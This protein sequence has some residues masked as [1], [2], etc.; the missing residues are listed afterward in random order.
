MKEIERQMKAGRSVIAV[1]VYSSASKVP[2]KTYETNE[3]LS[4]LRAENIKYDIMT[5]FQSN[6]A[7]S[8][9]VVVTIRDSVVAGPEYQKDAQNRKKYRVYQYVE[10]LTE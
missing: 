6:T 9:K 5:Y 4:R 10:V 7:I 8:E 3:K 2:T 1:N